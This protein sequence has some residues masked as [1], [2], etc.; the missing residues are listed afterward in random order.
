MFGEYPHTLIFNQFKEHTQEIIKFNE[1]DLQETIDWIKSTIKLIYDE[2]DFSASP[3]DF[4]C[5]YLCSS[6]DE[7]ASDSG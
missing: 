5:A 6:R 1:E 2:K 4:F 3:N 7:C